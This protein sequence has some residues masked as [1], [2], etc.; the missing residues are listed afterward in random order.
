VMLE[1]RN[2]NQS[3]EDRDAKKEPPELTDDDA[4]KIGKFEGVADL[5]AKIK[6]NIGKEKEVRARDKKRAEMIEVLVSALKVSVPEVLIQ[7]E[8]NKMFA[9]F[10]GDVQRMGLKPEDYLK[11]INKTE[12][13]LFKEWRVDAEKSAKLELLLD[14]V[15]EE[16]K[17]LPEEEKI[18]REV[19]HLTLHY[20]DAEP[21][22][23]RTYVENM[24]RNDMVFEFLEGQK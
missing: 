20:K 21:E 19:E 23:I 7:S 3:K 18:K 6:E 9:Q 17:L 13:D 15:A 5:K 24:L 14:R 2:A 11:Q 10:S 12:Q 1:I 16:E 4:K 22:R 8:L